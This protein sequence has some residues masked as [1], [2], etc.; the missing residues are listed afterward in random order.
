[1]GRNRATRFAGSP[2]QVAEAFAPDGA[3]LD[4][5]LH[6]NADFTCRFSHG[7]REEVKRYSGASTARA[8]IVRR[9]CDVVPAQAEVLSSSAAGG[10]RG[11]D[12]SAADVGGGPGR[13]RGRGRRAAR[14]RRQPW[15]SALVELLRAAPQ[16]TDRYTF[17]GKR[18]WS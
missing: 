13:R 12:A 18:E 5:V 15:G 1:M 7:R 17:R 16:P 9:A 6:P 11:G 8:V 3:S 10:L 2:A 14:R 4:A